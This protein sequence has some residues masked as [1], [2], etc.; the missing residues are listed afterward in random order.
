MRTLLIS[1]IL[2]LFVPTV[3]SRGVTSYTEKNEAKRFEVV[4]VFV[5]RTTYYHAREPGYTYGTKVAWKEVKSAKVG[6]TCAVD[7]KKIPYGTKLYIPELKGILDDGVFRAEDCG[8]AVTSLKAI[9]KK[10]RKEINHVIDIFVESGKTMRLLE[11]TMPKYMEVH[12]LR[13]V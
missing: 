6:R 11:R 7:P 8:S 12:V 4:D 13:E 10:L 1:L 3:N 5:V 9:P 2:C